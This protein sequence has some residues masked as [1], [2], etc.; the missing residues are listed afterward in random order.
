MPTKQNTA[1]H[2]EQRDARLTLRVSSRVSYQLEAI[3]KHEGNGVSSVTRRLLVRA[4]ETE[5][6]QG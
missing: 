3:A 1:P 6:E 2:T 4:L 5:P